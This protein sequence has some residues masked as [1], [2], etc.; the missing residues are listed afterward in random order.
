L[1]GWKLLEERHHLRATKIDAQER[2]FLLIN[3]MQGEH[4][5]ERVEPIRLYWVMDG[6]GF[7]YSQSQFW[8]S[9]QWGRPPQQF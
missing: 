2:S 3:A 4:G 9:M 5:L 1:L 7:G 8:H 6:S